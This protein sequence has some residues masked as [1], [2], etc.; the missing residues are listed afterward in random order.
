MRLGERM[1]KAK[2]T[3]ED[4]DKKI[5]VRRESQWDLRRR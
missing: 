2:E 3:I 5:M 4:I 1:Q